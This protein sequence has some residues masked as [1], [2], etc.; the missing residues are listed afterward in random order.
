MNSGPGN[1]PY[2]VT[3]TAGIVTTGV[4]GNSALGCDAASSTSSGDNAR[5]RNTVD[6]V[7]RYRG[8]FGPVGV[9]ATVGGMYGGRVLDNSTPAK[10]VQF[11]NF[12]VFD[13]GAQVTYGG[14]L[15]GAHLDY[16]KFNGQW[17]LA[18][19]GTSDAL[20]YVVGA[21]YTTGPIV[22]GASFYDYWSAGSKTAV[23]APG[24]GNRTEYGINVGG[25]YQ[26]AQGVS[27]YLFGLYG[28]RHEVGVDLLSGAT[29]T[30]AA[31]VRTNNNTR[32]VGAALGTLFQW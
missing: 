9:A 1:C 3:A 2:G 28:A 8:A 30:A 12:A 4:G 5:R 6:S 14:L 29:G 20:A 22:F 23:S 11:S 7:V 21:S 13:T 26:L 31:P 15:I 27:L 19:Q 32:V 16:G 17:A 25:T 18:P 10:S 24:I